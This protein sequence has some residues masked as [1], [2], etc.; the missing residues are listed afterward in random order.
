MSAHRVDLDHEVLSM[1]A[2][3]PGRHV[4][5]AENGIAGRAVERALE[6]LSPGPASTDE[7][8]AELERALGESR[9]GAGGLL[10]LPWLAGSMSPAASTDMRGG[11]LGMSLQTERADLLRSTVEGVARNL[12]WLQPAVT[13]LCGTTA[14]EIVFAGGGARSEG[15]AQVL[16]DVLGLPVLVP[17]HPEVAAARAVGAVALAHT[18]GADPTHLDA[19]IVRRHEPDVSSRPVHDRLQPIFE[20]AFEANRSICEAL[21]HE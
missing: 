5:M 1:P 18:T 11:Y 15:V 19:R 17:E 4:V 20:A 12:R 13:A 21:G 14:T 10:F 16:A 2:P 6:V 8:F 7:R 9:P 3:L